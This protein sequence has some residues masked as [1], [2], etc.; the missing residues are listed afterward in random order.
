[1]S[2]LNYSAWHDRYIIVALGLLSVTWLWHWIDWCG[3]WSDGGG[4]EWE[5]GAR[6]AHLHA[7]AGGQ[8]LPRVHAGG[9]RARHRRPH[10][11]SARRASECT[12]FQL[13]S[14]THYLLPTNL[15]TI[16]YCRTCLPT[17]LLFVLPTYLLSYLPT[18]LPTYL[19][20]YLPSVLPTYLLSYYYP[21]YLP[22]VLLTDDPTYLPTVLPTDDPTYLIKSNDWGFRVFL[23]PGVV[24][25]FKATH[26]PPLG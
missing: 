4:S 17:Y 14:C 20:T 19:P 18:V 26:S 12:A 1:V 25:S 7:G 3:R 22:T 15:P 5:V 21:T 9:D 6:R 2:H 13:V 8:V 24:R 11:Q 16:C 23:V 10:P